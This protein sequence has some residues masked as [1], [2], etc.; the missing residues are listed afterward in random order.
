MLVYLV[1][2]G[3]Y[4]GGRCKSRIFLWKKERIRKKV[5]Q[6]ECQIG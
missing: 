3:I 4:N 5:V 1:F 2:G 6:K